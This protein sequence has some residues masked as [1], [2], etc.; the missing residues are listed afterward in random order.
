M[1]PFTDV[2]M[3]YRSVVLYHLVS[4]ALHRRASGRPDEIEIETR[5]VQQELGAQVRLQTEAHMPK[6]A[7]DDSIDVSM[8]WTTKPRQITDKRRQKSLGSST[9]GLDPPS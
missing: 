4:F 6:F 8:G 3:F 1:I 2:Q 5:D 7:S 9:S